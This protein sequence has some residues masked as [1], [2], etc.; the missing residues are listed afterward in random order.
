MTTDL[1]GTK[2]LEKRPPALSWSL[3][4]STFLLKCTFLLKL[5][6][7]PEKVAPPWATTKLKFCPSTFLLW[8]GVGSTT[9]WKQSTYLNYTL[10]TTQCNFLITGWF[11]CQH[12]IQMAFI[13]QWQIISRYNMKTIYWYRLVGMRP[14]FLPTPWGIAD[15]EDSFV[16]N[17]LFTKTV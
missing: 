10:N 7:F 4:Y 1:C 12:I 14:L 2:L 15:F 17:F 9:F 13:Y 3:F 16:P 6:N 8:G 11:F 5:L